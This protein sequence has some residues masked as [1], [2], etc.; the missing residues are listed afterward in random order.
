MSSLQAHVL[1]TRCGNPA[2]TARVCLTSSRACLGRARFTRLPYGSKILE[3][4]P[5]ENQRE[6]E[7]ETFEKFLRLKQTY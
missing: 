7:E 3:N 6:E 2:L 5:L 1:E 4:I